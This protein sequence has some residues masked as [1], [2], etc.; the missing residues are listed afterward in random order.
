MK[1]WANFH[2]ALESF[3]RVAIYTII[4]NGFDQL[5]RLI[6]S[7]GVDSCGFH[8]ANVCVSGGSGILFVPIEHLL[9]P[10]QPNRCVWFSLSLGELHSL[11]VLLLNITLPNT[12]RTKRNSLSSILTLSSINAKV[13]TNSV[14]LGLQKCPCVLQKHQ[15]K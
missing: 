4:D 6:N 14:K 9:L 13:F 5:H 2:Y 8:C 10:G 3:T 12:C 11:L 15:P 7:S 1:N